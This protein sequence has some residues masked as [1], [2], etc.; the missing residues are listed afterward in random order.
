MFLSL[1]NDKK[2]IL[3][4]ELD[5]YTARTDGILHDKEKE[6]INF[7]CTE[8]QVENNDFKNELSFEEVI[9][10]ICS[11]FSSYEK[12]MI[13]LELYSIVMADEKYSRDEDSFIK[14]LATSFDISNESMDTA[15]AAL[16]D[17]KNAYTEIHKFLVDIK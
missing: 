5:L 11:S 10:E 13:F 4:R 8:M 12:R 2:K 3:F 9:K 15:F 14:E 6:I 17:L 7:H 1:L 16:V